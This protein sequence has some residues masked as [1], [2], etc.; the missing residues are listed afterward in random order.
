MAFSFFRKK[1]NADKILINGNIRTYDPEYPVA[2]CAAVKDGRFIAVGDETIADDLSGKDTQIIDLKGGWAVPGFTDLYGDMSRDCFEGTYIEL[3]EDMDA[4]GITAA[5]DKYVRA[6]A[7]DEYY[8]AFGFDSSLFD[9][10]SEDEIKAFR[11]K[12]DEICGET[13]FVMLSSDNLSMRMSTAAA[14][15]ASDAA[16]EEGRPFLT[17][18][19][20]MDTLINADYSSCIPALMKKAEDYASRGFTSV[21]SCGRSSYFDNIC[22]DLLMNA[23]QAGVLPQRF[24]GNYTITRPARPESVLIEMDRKFTYCQELAPLINSKQLIICSDS[25]EDSPRHIPKEHMEAYAQGC[26]ERGFSV[27]FIPR[28]RSADLDM[29][30]IAGD[31]SGRYRKLSF[32]VMSDA[33]FSDEELAEISSGEEYR[34][35]PSSQIDNVKPADGQSFGE[36]A[37]VFYSETAA[38]ILGFGASAGII[39]EGRL[40]DIAVYD[41]DPFEADSAE[42]FLA[43]RPSI[44]MMNGD[45]VYTKG[46]DTAQDWTKKIEELFSE[47]IPDDIEP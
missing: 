16:E 39:E 31:L 26:A 9:A 17:Q 10:S 24:F 32:S 12:L 35:S 18:G 14:K 37:C 34:L 27:R 44:V 6:H 25:D 40:A 8:F 42:V 33:E 2:A 43:L 4:D 21:L 47:D 36:A 46:G 22:R 5:V 1:N 41:T 7:D 19:F 20:V 15:M 29:S 38:K 45:I 11:E 30:D 23:Y 13:P 28:G 3:S